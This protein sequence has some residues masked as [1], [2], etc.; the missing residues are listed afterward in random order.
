MSVIVCL[1]STASMQLASIARV[2]NAILFSELALNR[3]RREAR[4]EDDLLTTED[5]REIEA[6]GEAFFSSVLARP[7][8]VPTR[9]FAIHYRE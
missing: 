3:A 4:K 6:I 1:A 7:P 5:Q 8:A 9:A 2:N